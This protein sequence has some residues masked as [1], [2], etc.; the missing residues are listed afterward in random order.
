MNAHVWSR[1]LVVAGLVGM[2]LGA[3]DPLEGCVVVLAGVALATGRVYLAQTRH[4]LLLYRALGMVAF[5]VAATIA[6]SAWGGIG[7]SSGHSLWWR[8]LMVP[9]PLGWLVG[10]TGTVLALIEFYRLR[11][12]PKHGLQ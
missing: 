5:G 12:L 6:L 3:V 7:G 4:R 2:L 1:M 10:L 11:S 8:L 9:Y